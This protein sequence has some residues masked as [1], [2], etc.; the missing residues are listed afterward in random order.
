MAGALVRASRLGS[1][2]ARE[3]QKSGE[4]T[5]LYNLNKKQ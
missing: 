4:G 3:G 2:D 1:K 5:H